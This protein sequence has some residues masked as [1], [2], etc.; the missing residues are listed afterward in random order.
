MCKRYV[1]HEVAGNYFAGRRIFSW[2]IAPYEK[3]APRGCALARSRNMSQET[4]RDARMSQGTF[5]FRRYA[6]I[7]KSPPD[8]FVYISSMDVFV[9]FV[10]S[11]GVKIG[12]Y[13][14]Y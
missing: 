11:Q 4:A 5:F 8:V 6:Q 12:T 14:I 9:T 1:K 2:E 7:R 3:N 10:H 13:Y